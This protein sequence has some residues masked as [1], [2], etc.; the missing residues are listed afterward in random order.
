MKLDFDQVVKRTTWLLNAERRAAERA[1]L[2]RYRV[3]KNQL[4]ASSLARAAGSNFVTA[5]KFLQGE[6]IRSDAALRLKRTLEAM[7]VVDAAS[8]VES[9]TQ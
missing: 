5:R 4:S 6:P 2:E 8:L 7:G 9:Q 1:D 3:K